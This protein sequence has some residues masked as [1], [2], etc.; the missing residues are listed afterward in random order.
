MYKLKTFP[1]DLIENVFFGVKLLTINSHDTEMHVSKYYPCI[2]I[3]VIVIVIIRIWID[4]LN[5]NIGRISVKILIKFMV[6]KQLTITLAILLS[7]YA[8]L[9]NAC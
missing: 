9:R 8:M 1:R 5:I 2:T 4:N 7:L 3:I 6:L